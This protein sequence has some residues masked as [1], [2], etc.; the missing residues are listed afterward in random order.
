MKIF[1]GG[2]RVAVGMVCASAAAVAFAGEAPPVR[3]AAEPA[4]PRWEAG[5]AAGFG[6][7]PDYPGAAQSRAR[8]IVLPMLI[9]RGPV[10]RIDGEGIR[11]RVFDSADWSLDLTATAAFNAKHNDLRQGM[12]RLDYLGGVGPQ[13]IYKGFQSNGSG[14]SVHLK[15]RALL[16]TDFKRVDPRGFSF[17][18]E[19]RWRQPAFAGMPSALTL[20]LQPTWATRSLHRYFYEVNADQATATRWA[21]AARPGYLGTEVAAT[22]S[23]RWA[24]NLS[25]FVTARYLS[26]HGA[27]N[28]AS[29]LLRERGN[30]SAGAGIVWTPWRS[31][32]S[33]AD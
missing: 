13:W 29:P 21:H 4:L 32:A 6:H 33:A 30:L 23:D 7:V 8:G 27:A 24:R 12:P 1:N 5:V 17:D 15:L 26:L 20:S 22:L 16:S 25:W 14:L 11:G 19:L 3:P 31:S 10:L 28:T 9:Y 18:P 2:V